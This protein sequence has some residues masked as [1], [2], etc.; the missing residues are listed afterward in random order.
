V[1]LRR[2]PL[3]VLFCVVAALVLQA[4]ALCF[5]KRRHS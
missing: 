4:F 1:K 2:N 3:A 5:M